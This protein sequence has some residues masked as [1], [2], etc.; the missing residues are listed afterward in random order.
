MNHSIHHAALFVWRLYRNALCLTSW[1][2]H[3]LIPPEALAQRFGPSD[4]GYSIRVFLSHF[5]RLHSAGFRSADRILEIGPG[6]NIGTALMWWAY[7]HALEEKSR[8]VA[9]WDIYANMTVDQASLQLATKVL[10]DHPDMVALTA[11]LGVHG[12]VA[13]LEA[14]AAGSQSPHIEYHVEPL[15]V[16]TSRGASYGLIYSQATIEHIWEIGDFWQTAAALTA[17]GGWHSHRIDL[18]DHGR[19]DTNYIEMLEWSPWAYWA[20]MRFIP[21]AINRWRAGDHLETMT[22]HGLRII[23]AERTTRDQLPVP[24]KYLSRR[25]RS[26]K[27]TELRTVALDVVARR[28]P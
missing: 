22:R 6:R 25:F 4:A 8:S 9:L 10:L 23:N 26:M 1:G 7:H 17:P 20:T 5:R 18:A 11:E 12:L 24:R 14:V 15:E 13:S 28:S 27:E 19:R 16:F 2:R 21:G 3:R